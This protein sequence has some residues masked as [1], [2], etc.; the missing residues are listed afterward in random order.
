MFVLPQVK[1]I[2]L[3]HS[4]RNHD[5]TKSKYQILYEIGRNVTETLTM[6]RKDHEDKALR[7][8]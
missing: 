7:I 8:S 5:R 1:P 4:L 6:L 3:W 2:S